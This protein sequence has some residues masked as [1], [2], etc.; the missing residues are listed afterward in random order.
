MHFASR[1]IIRRL[2]D[3]RF[4]FLNLDTCLDG[5]QSANNEKKI[6]SGHSKLPQSVSQMI[7]IERQPT[8]TT[9]NGTSTLLTGIHEE[10]EVD[11]GIDLS[12]LEFRL[13]VG[14]GGRHRG[15]PDLDRKT[16]WG[17]QSL[18]GTYVRPRRE[19][20]TM[21]SSGA[22]DL[23]GRSGELVWGVDLGGPPESDT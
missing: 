1:V 19:G 22:F 18:T 10:E 8:V 21:G 7:S 4:Q 13:E 5:R 12:I 14:L 2:A 6:Y 3:A 16:D 11:R 23:E 15:R 20:S 17:R 9:S